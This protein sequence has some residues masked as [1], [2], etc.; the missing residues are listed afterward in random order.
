MTE[1][2]CMVCQME[3][4]ETEFDNPDDADICGYCFADHATK[5]R[6]KLACVPASR[7]AE[8]LI[9]VLADTEMRLE[10]AHRNSDEKAAKIYEQLLRL[11]FA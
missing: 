6:R 8:R 4:D 1:Y 2:K 9:D 11:I 5:A 10:N 3:I 7:K